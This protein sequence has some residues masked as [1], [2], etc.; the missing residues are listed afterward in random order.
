MTKV[1]KIEKLR[2]LSEAYILYSASTRLP[3]AEC[4]QGNFFDEAY[5]FETREDAEKAAELINENGEA[6]GVAE[7]KTVPMD[8]GAQDQPGPKLMRNQLREHLMRLPLLG[9]NAV[10]FKPAEGRGET[11]ELD[12]V[13]PDPVKTELEKEKSSMGSLIGLRLTGIYFAQYLRRKEKDMNILRELSEEFYANLVRCELLLPVIPDEEHP[14]NPQLDLMSCQI[15]YYK[16]KRADSDETASFMALF[17]NMDEVVAH[18]RKRSDAVRVVKIPFAD[19]PKILRES[20]AGCVIDPLSMN[21]PI[22]GEDI[23]MMVER[24]TD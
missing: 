12:Y 21:L 22:R 10:F 2:A 6:V 23:P 14:D 15:P 1:E 17:T 24:L 20:M 3:Y 4:E 16:L 7:L 18:S 19:V 5:V 11:L 9:I 13:L 8:P